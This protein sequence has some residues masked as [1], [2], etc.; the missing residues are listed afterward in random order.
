MLS[1][2][3]VMLIFSLYIGRSQIGPDNYSQFLLSLRQSF[4]IFTGLCLLAILASLARGNLRVAE[5]GEC[6]EG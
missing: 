3:I 6:D 5:E 1:M 4:L 2:G